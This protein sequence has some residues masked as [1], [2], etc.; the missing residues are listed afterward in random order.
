MV[1]DDLSNTPN[2]DMSTATAAN[3]GI[4]PSDPLYLHPSKNPGA[5]LDSVP[6]SRI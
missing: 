2:G 3:S 1:V 6:F 4:D 5:M